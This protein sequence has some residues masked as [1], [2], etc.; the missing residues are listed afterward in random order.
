MAA[1][2]DDRKGRQTVP[3]LRL[4]RAQAAGAKSGSLLIAAGLLTVLAFLALAWWVHLHPVLAVDV[5]ITHAL[6]ALQNPW[7]SALMVAVSLIGNDPILSVG[8]VLLAALLLWLARLRLEALVLVGECLSSE[9]LNITV[10]ALVARPRPSRSLVEVMQS[11]HGA[12]FPSGHVMAYLAFWG[13]LLAYCLI[14]FKHGAPWRLLLM[15]LALFFLLLVGPSRIYLGDHWASDVL[16]GYLL[17][18]LWLFLWLF[19]YLRL[20]RRSSPARS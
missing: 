10:K 4:Q 8:L 3:G 12:S 15:A 2:P 1:A 14:V 16:G 5:A 11:A 19:L 9:L 13:M 7:L 6:Q 20:R 18:G 17:G